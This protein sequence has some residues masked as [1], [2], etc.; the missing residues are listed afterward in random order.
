MA[1]ADVERAERKCTWLW[2]VEKMKD[3]M[4][5][6]VVDRTIDLYRRVRLVDDGE[7]GT[8]NYR[9]I[10]LFRHC[11]SASSRLRT[12]VQKM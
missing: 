9:T 8:V 7:R 11:L 2:S 1:S 6:E 12:L 4:K 10:M 5:S 3:R